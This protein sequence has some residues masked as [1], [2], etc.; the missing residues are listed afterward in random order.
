MAFFMELKL[1]VIDAHFANLY[2]KAHE[3][4]NPMRSKAQKPNRKTKSKKFPKKE[5]QVKVIYSKTQIC[6]RIQIYR[7]I[8]L[9]RRIQ[10][11]G[12][13]ASADE[14]KLGPRPF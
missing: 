13:M 5:V 11:S 3:E 4:E 14:D 10:F 8:Q 2:P 7:R 6:C 9:Y 1:H 12:R